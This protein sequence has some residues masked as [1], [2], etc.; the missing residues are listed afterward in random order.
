MRKT[1]EFIDR[2]SSQTL[3]KSYIVDHKSVGHYA[4]RAQ[5]NPKNATT[6]KKKS[7]CRYIVHS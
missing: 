3:L 2:I 7:F 6:Q 1:F 5:N 4:R